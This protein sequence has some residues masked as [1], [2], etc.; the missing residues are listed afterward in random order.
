MLQSLFEHNEEPMDIYILQ[1]D[2]TK[3]NCLAL[4]SFIKKHGGEPHMICLPETFF[5]NAPTSIHITKQA[6][7]RLLAQELLPDDVERILY[8]DLDIVITGSLTSLYNETFE[9]NVEDCF[10]VVCEGPGV[11]QKE[12]DI[13]DVLEIP[14]EYKYFN[15]GVLL[16]NLSLLR[17]KFDTKILF[18]YIDSHNDS[19]KYH[20]QDTLNALFYNKVK[21]VDWHI[22]NQTILHIKS[23]EEAEERL[24][25]A[26]II[27]YA[28]SD[29]P[30]KYDYKSWYFDL[31]WKYARKAG[32]T[33]EYLKTIIKRQIWHVGNIPKKFCKK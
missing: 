27:H 4:E 30:W 25:N 7:Y 16:M 33:Q 6:Y 32:F 15:S 18:E 28:G 9:C 11:S 14:Y 3:Q 22:F 26:A 10:F 21:Y 17:E 23:K 12:W 2:L 24:K 20:D 31:Y 8:L 29:K 19:L 13:Y 5:D 1:S